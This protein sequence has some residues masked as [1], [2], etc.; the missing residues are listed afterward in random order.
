MGQ[1]HGI[2]NRELAEALGLDP[3]AAS[4]R[5]EAPRGKPDSSEMTKLL[6]VMRSMV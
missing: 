1:Q 3:S 2:G 6:K 5:R 4:K